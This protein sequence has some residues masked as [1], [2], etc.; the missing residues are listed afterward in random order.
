MRPRFPS[1]I[2][3]SRSSCVVEYC[4]AIDTTSRR[5]GSMKA[6]QA[7]SYSRRSR[8]ISTSRRGSDLG[9]SPVS[10]TRRRNSPRASRRRAALAGVGSRILSCTTAAVMRTAKRDRRAKGFFSRAPWKLELLNLTCR[11]AAATQKRLPGMLP[12]FGRLLPIA[13]DPQIPAV[14][15]QCP[16]QNFHARMEAIEGRLPCGRIEPL[17]VNDVIDAE[18]V[19]G[20]LAGR[21]QHDA[22]R[23]IV[24]QQPGEELAAGPADLFRD[25]QFVVAAEQRSLGDLPQIHSRLSGVRGNMASFSL[26]RRA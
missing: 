22:E 23:V 19:F 17:H 14:P 25:R 10:W 11:R 12:R 2:R 21:G 8:R 20:G 6:W 24:R 3:S 15:A 7:A 26:Q 9:L 5:F 18:L 4:F 1:W 13:G 16:S